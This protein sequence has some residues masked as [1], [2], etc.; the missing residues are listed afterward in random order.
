MRRLNSSK[1][2]FIIFIFFCVE[3]RASKQLEVKVSTLRI[4][5]S[6]LLQRTR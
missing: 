6:M 1:V 5:K 2:S 3:E 4:E